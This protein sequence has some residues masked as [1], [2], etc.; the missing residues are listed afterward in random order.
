MLIF[1]RD[2]AGQETYTQLRT[3]SYGS[4]DIF[5]I[6]F[7]V[8]DSSSFENALNK[9]YPELSQKEWAHIPK[10][11]VGNKIDMRDDNNPK[12]IRAEA[13]KALVEK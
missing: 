13:A 2:T 12:H 5:V 9:W 7:A 4:A 3:L 11:I 1:I 6:I 10:L 8:S